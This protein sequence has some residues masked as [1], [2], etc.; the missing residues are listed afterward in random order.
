MRRLLPGPPAE[1]DPFD[2]YRDQPADWLRLGLVVSADGSA[3]DQQ[4]WTDG[5]GGEADREVFRA[6][7]AACDGILVGATTIR[8]GKVGPHRLRED[9]RVRRTALGKPAP[10]PVIVVTRSLRLDWSHRL[11]TEAATPTIVV[12]CPAAMPSWPAGTAARPL[13]AGEAEV[14]LAAA[15]RAL[16]AEFGLRQLLCEGGPALATGML[17]AGLVDELCLTVA[18]TLI[19]ARHHTRPFGLASGQDLILTALYE[20]DGS[21]FARY[22]LGRSRRRWLRD[23]QD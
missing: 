16:R 10:A 13:V 23:Q 11:F 12:T 9:L 17:A 4:G 3:T 6:L 18:P 1:L 8:S 7:R 19:G 20:Q 5:L 22:R 14:D 15:V 21:L 2:A